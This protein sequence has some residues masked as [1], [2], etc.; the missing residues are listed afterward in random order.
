VIRDAEQLLARLDGT[1]WV[2]V[3]PHHVFPRYCEGLFPDE[4]GKIIDFAHVSKGGDAWFDQ[5][6]WLPEE[7]AAIAKSSA[8]CV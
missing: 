7:E 5:I 8:E 3:V 2:G 4:Y 1:D 6:V